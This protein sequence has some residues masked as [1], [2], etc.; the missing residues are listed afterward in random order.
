MHENIKPFVDRLLS[1]PLKFELAKVKNG[2]SFK[3]INNDLDNKDNLK[4]IRIG[5]SINNNATRRKR[6]LSQDNSNNESTTTNNKKVKKVLP[7][8]INEAIMMYM[9]DDKQDI[10]LSDKDHNKIDNDSDSGNSSSEEQEFHEAKEYISEEEE[11]QK[12]TTVKQDDNVIVQQIDVTPSFDNE[13]LGED[14]GEDLGEDIGEDIS[15]TSDKELK[16]EDPNN[17]YSKPEKEEESVKLENDK[18]KSVTLEKD[19]ES[20]EKLQDSNNNIKQDEITPKEEEDHTGPKENITELKKNDST[21]DE[22]N[23][24][25]KYQSIKEEEKVKLELPKKSI[26]LD[27]VYK[28]GETFADHGCKKDSRIIKN[29]GPQFST[30]KPKGLLN[31]GVT[32][33]TNA[34]V[35]A[36]LHVPSMQHYLMDVLLGK[37]SNKINKNSVTQVLAETSK[38]MWIPKKKIKN[39][40]HTSYIDPN[41]LIA[42]L[43]DINCM[44]S[45]WQQEDSHE[46]F[47]SLMSRLQEDSTPKGE[48][49]KNSIIHDMF[50]GLLK[51]SVTCQSCGSISITEQPFYD[52]SLHLKSRRC[53]V[54]KSINDFFQPELIKLDN[55]KRG[56]LCDKCHKTTNATKRNSILE[57]PETLL[58]H[59]KKFRFNGTSSSKM[60]QAVS[61]ESHLDLSDYLNKDTKLAIAKYELLSV[62]VHEGR[63]LSSGHYIAHC[64]QPDGTWATYDDEYINTITENS[65]LKEP[66]TYYLV[67]TRLTPRSV[68]FAKQSAKKAVNESNTIGNN[69][70][71]RNIDNNNNNNNNNKRKK[72]GKG[73]KTKKRKLHRKMN[74]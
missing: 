16:Q 4:F 68:T 63:S 43:D 44:M 32:C 21:K 73:N 12:D 7:K 17:G 19:Q 31:H 23:I 42:R 36:M 9:N 30:L 26:V 22:N 67:Y 6:S 29:W 47:M 62:V 15:N 53:S 46:Y 2:S 66:N 33:Y 57:A 38:K 69:N 37:Y 25:P 45:E 3:L 1:N 18:E 20:Y 58:V 64:K 48:K 34:A 41:S 52:L 24:E 8:N 40:S 70:T 74:I 35:Q 61:F 11:E 59:L 50:G 72:K 60:K 5:N 28:F 65:V 13:D 56:Y 51:Q 55:E 27:D 49:L 14:I 54:T 10:D 71:N 39:N